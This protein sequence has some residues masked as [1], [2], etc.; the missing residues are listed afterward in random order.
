MD[1]STMTIIGSAF[2]SADVI[3]NVALSPDGK[4]A[5]VLIDQY[6]TSSTGFQTVTRSVSVLDITK[7]GQAY[8][9]TFSVTVT[10]KNGASSTISVRVPISSAN[11]VPVPGTHAVGTPNAST[12]AVIGKVTATDADKDALSYVVTGS[13]A[14]TSKYGTVSIDANTG[15]FSY[16]PALNA[17][18]NAR[19]AGAT[20]DDKTDVF[21]VLINDG[22]GGVVYTTVTVKIA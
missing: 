6:V 21:S 18:R 9:D 15:T 5:Y 17:W 16:M 3:D 2:V 1:T 14:N 12:G 10:D 8:T 13:G 22:H 20:A 11:A 7:V 19:N 4:R